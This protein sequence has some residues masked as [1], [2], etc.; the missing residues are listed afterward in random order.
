MCGLWVVYGAVGPANRK[1]VDGVHMSMDR[2]LVE[3]IP[4]ETDCPSSMAS[5][6]F[7]IPISI[8]TPLKLSTMP[9]TWADQKIFPHRKFYNVLEYY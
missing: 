3:F 1:Q 2:V 5:P 6:Q 7:L 8:I 9:L 4:P